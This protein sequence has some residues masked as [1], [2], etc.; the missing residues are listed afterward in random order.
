MSYKLDVCTAS[1]PPIDASG[2]SQTTGGILC[3]Q[4]HGNVFNHADS[5]D[6]VFVRPH[7]GKVFVYQSPCIPD[8]KKSETFIKCEVTPQI[9]PVLKA[10]AWR[11]SPVSSKSYSLIYVQQNDFILYQSSIKG[12]MFM[13]M[14]IGLP[15]VIMKL[16]LK[17]M[18]T[19]SGPLMRLIH[20]ISLL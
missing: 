12:S 9:K 11:F 13:K 7:T 10:L 18:M 16:L 2:A 5:A 20:S 17:I 4:A 14:V 6:P 15:K 19:S 1:P 3:G 8:P